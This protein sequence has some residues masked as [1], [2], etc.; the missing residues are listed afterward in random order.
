LEVDPNGVRTLWYG[1][2]GGSGAF[3]ARYSIA[4][5]GRKVVPKERK[6]VVT[7]DTWK[8][9][10]GLEDRTEV[11]EEQGFLRKYVDCFAFGLHDLGIL[12]GQ[13]VRINLTDDAPI[14][15][16]PYKYSDVEH[17]MIQARIKEL[18]EAGL[19]ELAPPDCKYASATVM[20]SKKDIYGN[21][22]EKRMCGDYRRI[23]K[24]TK[25][26]RY[27]MPTPKENFE[28]IRH[29]KVFSTLDLYSRY[30]QIGLR[31]EDKEKMAF[32]GIDENGKDW[33]F[34]WKFLSFGL[35]NAPTKSQGV[36]D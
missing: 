10:V 14:F 16:K 17:K 36:M 7:K 15:R 5:K 1:G 12:N 34:Q 27:A 11:V 3:F 13:E 24:F 9:T 31:E 8:P 18:V 29:A 2:V 23:N 26:N 20:P 21:W 33:L 22:T 28:A 35:K 6:E 25:S 30:H 19:V 4:T 32:W